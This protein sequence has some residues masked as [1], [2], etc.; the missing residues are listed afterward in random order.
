MTREDEYRMLLMKNNALREQNDKLQ[1]SIKILQ[2]NNESMQI[3]IDEIVKERDMYKKG[4][5]DIFIKNIGSSWDKLDDK[6]KKDMSITEKVHFFNRENN[7]TKVYI[8]D[9]AYTKAKEEYEEKLKAEEQARVENE[10]QQ[11][12]KQTKENKDNLKAQQEKANDNTNEPP[13]P[14]TSKFAKFQNRTTNEPKKTDPPKIDILTKLTTMEGMER[15]TIF[16]K[17]N[18]AKEQLQG[19]TDITNSTKGF[20][21]K[22]LIVGIIG[23]TGKTTATEIKDYCLETY[24]Y[25]LGSKVYDPMKGLVDMELLEEREVKVGGTGRPT[26]HYALTQLGK[27]VWANDNGKNP[28]ESKI[29]TVAREQ[30]SASHGLGINKVIGILKAVGY[31]CDTEFA[32]IAEN[33]QDTIADIVATRNGRMYYIEFEEG[34]YNEAGY[35]TK[36]ENI[37]SITDHMVFITANDEAKRKIKTCWQRFCMKDF[38]RYNSKKVV[39][40]TLGKLQQ[41]PYLLEK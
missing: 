22:S 27:Y 8:R 1:G 17:I 41:D 31:E 4:F 6:S 15:A 25:D 26:K 13:K 19:T 2:A 28:V 10:K 14:Q 18:K 36:F 29:D 39:I 21:A 37:L 35:N 9:I 33:G 40:E 30:K 16:N 3:K 38:A 12:A 20:T 11:E 34:N 24:G 7:N 5:E 32:R 23:D